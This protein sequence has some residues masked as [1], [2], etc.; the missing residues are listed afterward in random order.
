M[1][2]L[3]TSPPLADEDIGRYDRDRVPDVDEAKARYKMVVGEADVPPLGTGSL[4]RTNQ[5]PDA[6][7]LLNSLGLISEGGQYR[8]AYDLDV[9]ALLSRMSPEQRFTIGTGEGV[10]L[11]NN[12]YWMPYDGYM[13]YTPYNPKQGGWD[14]PGSRTYNVGA[15]GH[16]PGTKMRESRSRR[17]WE[18]GP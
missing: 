9:Q 3:I 11:G 18:G 4:S 16:D 10:V 14:Y 5:D 1:R 7:E 17:R 13:R 2:G 12:I 6:V 8:A 15:V